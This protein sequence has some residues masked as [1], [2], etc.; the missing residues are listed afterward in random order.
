M[1]KPVSIFL[2][3]TF[4]ALIL[5]WSIGSFFTQTTVAKLIK[6]IPASPIVIDAQYDKKN[7]AI[8][9]SIL[10]SGG[11]LLKITQEAFVFTPGQ[12]SNQK[13]YIVSNI[14]VNIELKPG[15]ITRFEMKLKSGTEKL[16]FGDV[17]LATFTY[18]N[19]L[20]PDLYT[21]VHSFKLKNISSSKKDNGGKK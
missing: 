14:P 3:V 1:K 21:V 20:S 18:M 8:S 17:V 6:T 5:G 7:H 4:V 12:K 19:P 15:I 9:Y 2:I 11:T 16:H 13:E 10:N